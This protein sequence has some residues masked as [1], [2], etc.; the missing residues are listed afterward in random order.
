MF[1]SEDDYSYVRLRISSEM[2]QHP[3]S[4]DTTSS[5]C[6]FKDNRVQTSSTEKL[7]Q[8]AITVGSYAE[9]MHFYALSAAFGVTV[10]L[11]V[12]P[13]TALGFASSPYSTVVVGRG[14]RPTTSPSFTLM[15][16]MSRTLGLKDPVVP[17]HIVLLAARQDVVEEL[18]VLDDSD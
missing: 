12:P 4:Y 9:L 13:T 3:S 10:G 18:V 17:N 11:Y 5:E 7:V 14:V 1:G 8:D 15:W 16:T 6:T 2:L